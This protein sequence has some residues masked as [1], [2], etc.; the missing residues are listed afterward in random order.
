MRPATAFA[1][2]AYTW[3][4]AWESDQNYV[5][6]DYQFISVDSLDNYL[7]EEHTFIVYDQRGK[8]FT[9]LSHIMNLV[10]NPV[11]THR[12]KYLSYIQRNDEDNGNH[13]IVYDLVFHDEVWNS[14]YTNKNLQFGSIQT[15]SKNQ[16]ATAP[17]ID[18]DSAYLMFSV[19]K[20]NSNID[21]ICQAY[22]F[23]VDIDAHMIY[24][25]CYTNEVWGKMDFPGAHYGI[26]EEN[27]KYGIRF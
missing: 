26:L 1:T 16:H 18:R 7:D 5:I 14:R 6:I 13:V 4:T 2:R 11:I 10:T 21:G 27:R 20:L 19:T 8:E 9:R 17:Y 3:I 24:T 15:L 25:G 22:P 23:Y 12:G